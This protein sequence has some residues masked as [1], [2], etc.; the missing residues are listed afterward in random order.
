MVRSIVNHQSSIL[1]SLR[2]RRADVGEHFFQIGIARLAQIERLLVVP[3]GERG[4][5][6]PHERPAARDRIQPRCVERV[7][8]LLVVQRHRSVAFARP[9][10]SGGGRR[11][12]AARRTGHHGSTAD[13]RSARERHAKQRDL[14]RG[15]ALLR[16]RRHRQGKARANLPRCGSTRCVRRSLQT[17][18]PGAGGRGLAQRVAKRRAEPAAVG[19]GGPGHAPGRGRTPGA[20]TR[21]PSTFG[22]PR[23]GARPVG[24]R[25]HAETDGGVPR[26]PRSAGA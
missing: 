2:D 17:L 4:P 12:R 11:T 8:A 20:G 18:A 22:A 9:D 25:L 24:D 26:Q 15:P 6:R 23:R 7:A 16:R 10:S 14:Q 13:P 3:A 19:R 21:A 1:N 5:E